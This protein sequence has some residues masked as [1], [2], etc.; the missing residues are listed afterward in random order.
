MST[1][2]IIT[3]SIIALFIILVV[4]NYRKMKNIKPVADSDK[5]KILN[6]K[7]FQQQIKNGITLVDFWAVWCAPCK[8]MAPVLNEVAEK[9]H[10]DIKIGKLNIEHFQ[11]IATRY[12]IKSI[13]TMV[14]FKNGKEAGRFS[15]VKSRDFIIKQL[16]NI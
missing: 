5:I 2:F 9:V 11:E 10:S 7:N 8:M 16:N 13:P 15:G 6:N 14:I 3:G 12:K 1:A 4:Y